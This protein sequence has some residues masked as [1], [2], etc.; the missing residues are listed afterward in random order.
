MA[1][2]D[3]KFLEKTYLNTKSIKETAKLCG[4]TSSAILWWVKKLGIYNKD[5]RYKKN[6][7]LIK[8]GYVVLF[9]KN[10]E[11]ILI[12]IDDFDMIR[13]YKWCVS[14][15]GYAVAN[16]G[17]CVIKMHRFILHANPSDIIDHKNRN[18]LDNRRNNLRFCS[19]HQNSM[20]CS[21][22]KGRELPIGIR[23]RNGKYVARIM[24]NRKE[25]N[26]GRYLTL[27][28]AINARIAGEKK[29]FN[30]FRT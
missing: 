8:D 15:T 27:E 13:G 26:L 19:A 1:K 24:I 25:V 12:D 21:N 29:Y 14:K 2:I 17:G 22:T 10:G 5:W 18:K 6:D 3:S 7:F 11:E 9:A 4:V 16:I 20:N 23:I 30:G 28:E